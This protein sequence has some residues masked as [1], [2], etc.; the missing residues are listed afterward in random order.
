MMMRAVKAIFTLMMFLFAASGS[1]AACLPTNKQ[2]DK[3]DPNMWAVALVDS[4]SEAELSTQ[5]YA[6][7]KPVQSLED[8]INQIATQLTAAKLAQDDLTCAAR[9]IGPFAESDDMM[10]QAPAMVFK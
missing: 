5:R 9:M 6:A 10:L 3:R 8:M 4:L 1:F 7:D 2:P